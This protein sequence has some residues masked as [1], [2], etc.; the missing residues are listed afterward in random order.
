MQQR[1]RGTRWSV[2]RCA[3]QAGA[4]C[5]KSKIG[6]RGQCIGTAATWDKD[7]WQ[8]Q[9]LT[10][11]LSRLVAGVAQAKVVANLVQH[12]SARGEGEEGRAAGGLEEWQVGRCTACVHVCVRD[13]RCH[14]RIAAGAH[15]AAVQQHKRR[16]RNAALA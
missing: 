5:G 14:R 4:G 16:A 10:C 9:P 2:R 13:R 3:A 12:W 1:K 15:S 11:W 7:A 6:R 8:L